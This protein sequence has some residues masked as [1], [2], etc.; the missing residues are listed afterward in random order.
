LVY[1]PLSTTLT[2]K[3]KKIY[4][5]PKNDLLLFLLYLQQIEAILAQ[6]QDI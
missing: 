6:W 5:F 2:L 3:N 4:S 1:Y